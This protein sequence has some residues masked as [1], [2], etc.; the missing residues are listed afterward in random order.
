[1]ASLI[2]I[3]VSESVSTITVNGEAYSTVA[4]A[5]S[6]DIPVVNSAATPI[7]TITPGGDVTIPDLDITVNGSAYGSTPATVDFDV[8][9]VDTTDA[10]VNITISGGK[11]IIDD[12]PCPPAALLSAELMKTGVTKFDRIGG[13][14]DLQ[15]GRLVDFLTIGY[16]NPFGNTKR[17]TGV[18]GGYQNADLSYSDA[19]GLATTSAL[20]VPDNL[21]LDWSTYDGT[22]VQMY[23][24]L[25]RAAQTWNSAIDTALTFTAGPYSGFWLPN[26]VESLSISWWAAPTNF[27]NRYSYA[28]FNLASISVWVSNEPDWDSSSGLYLPASTT[29]PIY[30]SIK[31]ANIQSLVTR[32][33]TVT[34]TVI[35]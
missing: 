11:V 31:T 10:P 35:T 6:D 33:A 32:K 16:T 2:T 9:V 22:T 21:V 27:G 5:G 17:F 1:M 19:S 12:L 29:I 4:S 20:A 24:R 14:G 8:D 23:S 3:H 15:K 7:G 34:G 28:P 13:D 18:T 25:L 30:P 26:I